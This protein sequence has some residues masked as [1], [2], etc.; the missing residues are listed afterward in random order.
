MKITRI[1]VRN[2][3][4][5]DEDL[6]AGPIERQARVWQVATL[7][8]F[9]DQGVDGI[10]IAGSQ[11]GLTGALASALE[12]MA[13]L[14]VGDDP[15]RIE[16]I[17]AKLDVHGSTFGQ[18]GIFL[19]A[20]SAIDSALWDIKGKMA[21]LPLWKL[22]GGKRNRVP[23]YASGPMHRALTNE[24]VVGAAER[25]VAKGFRTVKMHLALNGDTTPA[26]EFERARLVREAIGPEVRLV[27]DINE[28]WR[29][30]EAIQ[31]G[32]LLEELDF[33]WLEDP[34]R[35]D[36]LDGLARITAALRTPVMAGE[37]VWGTAP[38][39]EMLRKQ[40][41]D[42]LMIDLLHVGGITHWM[43]VA[44]MAELFNVPVVSHIM[45]EFQAQIIAAVPNGLIAEYKS[46]YWRLFDGVPTF[47]NGELVLS[48][49]PGHGL[50]F[51]KEFNH[52]N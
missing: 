26:K 37:A 47:E 34:T 22:L 20:L 28:R 12:E 42:I 51:S 45:P 1:Q 21:G 43:K 35:N 48:E 9:T 31:I 16:V 2:V 18:S 39:R 52:L 36:D 11:R 13:G 32:T 8:I 40:S 23:T 10:G 19:S 30:A 27:C 46:W 4:V 6:I 50:S 29:T 15:T 14:L 44:A 3:E 33:F 7:R 38:F 49:R 25:I 5:P 17:L 41:L 24:Q